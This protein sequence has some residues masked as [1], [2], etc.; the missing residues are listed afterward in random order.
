MSE[1]SLSQTWPFWVAGIGIGLLV[2]LLAWVTGKAFGVSTGY[3]SLCSMVSGL[4]YFRKKP[5]T[6]PWRL[7]FIAGIPI[8]DFLSTLLSGDLSLKIQMGLFETVFGNSLLIKALILLIG[9]FLI[10]YG[11]R[12]AGG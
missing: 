3:G 9:G 10:G 2:V 1:F 4:S 11:A 8:G 5:F 6:D 7:W 12:W